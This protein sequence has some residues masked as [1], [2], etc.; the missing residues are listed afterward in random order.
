MDENDC[1]HLSTA[2]GYRYHISGREKKSDNK[3]PIN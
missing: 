1:F 2:D 3:N